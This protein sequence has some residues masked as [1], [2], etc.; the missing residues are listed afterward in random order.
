MIQQFQGKKVKVTAAER[1]RIML[2][3]AHLLNKLRDY[4]DEVGVPLKA[5]EEDDFWNF[6]HLLPLDDQSSVIN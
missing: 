4:A 5:S 1:R 2:N 3:A 6:I